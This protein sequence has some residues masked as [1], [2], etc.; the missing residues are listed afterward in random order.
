M[1]AEMDAIKDEKILLWRFSKKD[2]QEDKRTYN[3]E[4]SESISFGD[5][6]LAG[7]IEDGMYYSNI[8]S[9]LTNYSACLLSY[10]HI[11]TEAIAAKSRGYINDIAL[12]NLPPHYQE[13]IQTI[14]NH[15]VYTLNMSY[16]EVYSLSKQGYLKIPLTT[17][18]SAACFQNG[19]E[20]HPKLDPIIYEDTDAL[21][22]IG[23]CVKQFYLGS[24]STTSSSS[25]SSSSSFAANINA[26]TEDSSEILGV[27][28]SLES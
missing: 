25:S 11:H 2:W 10:Y 5:S 14:P 23:S 19:E 1:F 16:S 24:D 20:F 21:A 8:A 9:G 28:S 3:S 15:Q 13:Y 6:L 26:A 17:E 22:T 27:N 12:D 4:D 7:Y 18:S